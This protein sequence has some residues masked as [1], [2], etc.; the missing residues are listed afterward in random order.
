MTTRLVLVDD[1][2]LILSGL[3]QVLRAESG[4]EILAKCETTDEA[5]S[6]ISAGH[7]DIVL[8]DLNLTGPD[9]YSLM[10]RLDPTKPPF[11]VILTA[12]S[13]ERMLRDA[14]LLG[15]R[16]I[17]LKATAPR[18][19]ETCLRTVAAGGRW[20]TVNGVD[21]DQRVAARRAIEAT[22]RDSLTPR[23]IEIVRLVDQDLDNES[24][25]H[26]LDISVGTVKIHLHHIFDKLQLRGRQE[27]QANLQA[28]GY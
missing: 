28:R 11:V 15:A 25:A 24:I 3:D 22:L 6:A 27:L 8:L 10:R 17:V 4:F 1:H 20:L 9:G 2:P 7:P 26:R 18:V 21:L 23:E 14:V 12:V 5:W 16:G 19:L 13:D